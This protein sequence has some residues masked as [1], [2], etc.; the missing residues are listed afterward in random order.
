MWNSVIVVTLSGW[1]QLGW[2]GWSLETMGRL[3]TVLQSLSQCS[4]KRLLMASCLTS[5]HIR[6]MAFSPRLWPW[7]WVDEKSSLTEWCR[8][9]Q[10]RL[11]NYCY[12]RMR[13]TCLQ[14][15]AAK[16]IYVCYSFI[17]CLVTLIYRHD[18]SLSQNTMFS[19]R[20]LKVIC[21][22]L[23]TIWPLSFNPHH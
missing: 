20:D 13:Q 9:S 12:F 21:Q 3:S 6:F 5:H 22:Y 11:Q 18:L 1:Y 8:M 2:W 15:V 16:I 7:L 14:I 17:L 10:K 23:T 19:S 4:H